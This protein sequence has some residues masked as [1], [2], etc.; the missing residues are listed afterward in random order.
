[1]TKKPSV[2][3]CHPRKTRN[4]YEIGG[5]SGRQYITVLHGERLPLIILYKGENLYQRMGGAVGAAS[6][7]I[8]Q[9]RTKTALM[10][11]PP[12]ITHLLQPL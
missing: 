4:A 7:I 12:N 11:L 6:S 2:L 8:H 5:G 10:C 9:H 1:M 3:Q